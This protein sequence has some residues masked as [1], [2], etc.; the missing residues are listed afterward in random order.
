[1]IRKAPAKMD[2]RL[3]WNAWTAS[4]SADAAAEFLDR[5][6]SW[7]EGTAAQLTRGAT[8]HLGC[9]L[10]RDEVA[11]RLRF[12]LGVVAGGEPVTYVEALGLARQNVIE[13]LRS[14]TRSA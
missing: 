2:V 6:G 9:R 4:G 8:R 10:T 3:A 14:G 11:D 12:H 5:I 7:T 13:E 1:M